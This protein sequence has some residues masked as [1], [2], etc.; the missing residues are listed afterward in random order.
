MERSKS[1]NSTIHKKKSHVE[2]NVFHGILSISD[3]KFN[4]IKIYKEPQL[5]DDEHRRSPVHSKK[6]HMLQTNS[7]KNHASNAHGRKNHYDIQEIYS[8]MVEDSFIVF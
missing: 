5:D 4:E 3:L 7:K 8:T 2:V 1:K 6:T